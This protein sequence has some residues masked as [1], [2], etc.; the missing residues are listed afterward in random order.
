MYRPTR[1]A[2]HSFRGILPDVWVC[3]C[4]CVC[5]IVC[6]L[7]NSKRDGQGPISAVVPQKA[8]NNATSYSTEQ[9][10]IP[11]PPPASGL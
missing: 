8:F 9:G 2:D 10:N 7:E 5:L 1:R 4:V 3:V 11:L 6:D